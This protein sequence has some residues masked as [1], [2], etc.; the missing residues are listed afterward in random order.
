[1]L[2]PAAWLHRIASYSS[3]NV[4]RAREGHKAIKAMRIGNDRV[5]LMR[6]YHILEENRERITVPKRFLRWIH[7]TVF[8]HLKARS[9]TDH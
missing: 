2:L 5:A 3:N 4:L 6:Q 9:R 1:M 7:S 8:S